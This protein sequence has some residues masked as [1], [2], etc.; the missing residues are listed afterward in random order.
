MKAKF[1]NNKSFQEVETEMNRLYFDTM[2]K[3]IKTSENQNLEDEKKA[4]INPN[5]D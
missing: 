5:E 2:L 4:E 3:A 1:R